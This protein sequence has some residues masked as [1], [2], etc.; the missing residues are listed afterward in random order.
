MRFTALMLPHRSRSPSPL[1]CSP[2][3]SSLPS[4]LTRRAYL[5]SVA[6]PQMKISWPVMAAASSESRKAVSA[7]TSS[8]GSA[9][10]SAAP[11]ARRRRARDPPAWRSRSSPARPRS[12]SRRA[13]AARPPRSAPAPPARPSMPHI[14]CAPR[15]RARTGSRSARCARPP[16]GRS[17]ARRQ[18]RWRSR[19]AV[20]TASRHRA[21]RAH[22]GTTRISPARDDRRDIVEPRD[23]GG[24]RNAVG[25]VHA[26]R[27]E[28][29]LCNNRRRPIQ[30]GHA[31]T[32]GEQPARDSLA[33]ARVD[34]S[35]PRAACLS[36][37][38]TSPSAA[39]RARA[40]SRRR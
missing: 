6:P 33:D 4:N 40:R 29:G 17:R 23:R 35:T 3:P 11:R 30:P 25:E 24:A 12:R 18:A 22:R 9:A 7:A 2:P 8:A 10:R 20:A 15:R 31:P 32:A 38:R 5:R 39:V 19:H 27:F 28:R 1:P 14:A 36:S 21:R 37:A 26:D 16:A 34:P 13:A